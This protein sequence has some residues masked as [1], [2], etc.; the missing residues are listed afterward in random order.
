MPPHNNLYARTLLSLVTLSL[1][2]N[3]EKETLTSH[4]IEEE[5]TKRRGGN[6]KRGGEEKEGSD[7]DRVT[8]QTLER[9]PLLFDA[10]RFP[11]PRSVLLFS[12]SVTISVALLEFNFDWYLRN[13]GRSMGMIRI[14]CKFGFN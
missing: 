3:G 1:L 4:E 14:C 12:L 10:T 9:F 6:P 8:E 11:F 13:R 2:I 7:D 5:G